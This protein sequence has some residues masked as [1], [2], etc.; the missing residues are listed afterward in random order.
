[1]LQPASLGQCSIPG[2]PKVW[3]G[4][5]DPVADSTRFLYFLVL[6]G[7]GGSVEG[8]WGLDVAGNERSGPMGGASGQ[9]SH[10]TKTIANSC[11]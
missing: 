10:T 7:D 2:S 5:P 11:P 1:M 8:S 9:C 6:A 4:V 3:G